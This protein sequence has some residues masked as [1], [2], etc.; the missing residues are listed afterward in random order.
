[1]RSALARRFGA[2]AGAF[3]QAFANPD[4]RRLQLAGVGSLLGVWMYAIALF[5]YAFDVGGAAGVGLVA[6]IRYVPAALASPF[7]A[8]LGDRYPRVRVMLVSDLVRVATLSAA[9]LTIYLDGPPAL[10]FGLAAVASVTSTAFGPAKKAVLP[11]LARSPEELTASN[12]VTSTI[13]SVAVFAG[14]ALGGLL[15]AATSAEAVFLVTALALLWSALLI[16]RMEG[17]RE[18]PELGDDRRGARAIPRELA[19]G[20][21]VA[22]REPSVRLILL[23]TSAQTF[24]FGVLT[25]LIVVLALELL[26]IGE[27][28]VGFLNSALG[29][30]GLAGSLAAFALIGRRRLAP[31]FMVGIAA[32]GLPLVAV[33]LWPATLLALA[34]FAV[35]G[36][37]N[38]I[39]DVAGITLL[40]RAA[41]E[42]VLARVFGVLEGLFLPTIA[43][44]GAAPPLLIALLG[45]RGALVAAGLLLPA[46]AL[47]A[48]RPLVRV[49]AAAAAPGR[50]LDL[51]RAL[52][53]FAPLPV[54]TLERLAAALEP[55]HLRA[56]EAVF[57]QGDPGDRFYVVASGTVDVD[58]DGEPRPPLG[59]GECFGEIAL[60]RDVPRTAT[61]AAATD[62]E[63]YAL[64]RDE[65]IAAVTG[66][67]ESARAADRVVG[68]RLGA[69]RAAS[70]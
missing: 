46:L 44:G 58:V 28:G 40:Q 13:D 66:H 1:M 4:I 63:L 15:L 8:L 30:G 21:V 54:Q 39:V 60:L 11:S 17:G 50:Q 2:S 9:A 20:F 18:A 7:T 55:V 65:F 23:L 27:I 29:L 3:A 61:V 10:V 47:L 48:W 41:H 70:T 22:A 16:M 38:T 49:E 32:W 45:R 12:V 51:L 36:A 35:I 14:P 53:M 62:V 64:D 56:G 26:A 6:L 57:R 37:A 24:V 52:P 59:A 25:V 31:A 19:A 68:E 42:R 67:P 43:L 69:F 5:V 34:L 33:G